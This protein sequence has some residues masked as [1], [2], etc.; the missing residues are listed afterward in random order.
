MKL[1]IVPCPCAGTG[2]N[3]AIASITRSATRLEVS[4]L[5]AVTAAGGRAFSS[6]PSGALI[7]TGR[8]APAE[9]G[10]SGSQTTR[11]A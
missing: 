6:E 9:G 7:S 8:Q 10:A 1:F 3:A 2:L 4:T 5:P 11:T